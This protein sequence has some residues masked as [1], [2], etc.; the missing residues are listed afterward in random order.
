[1]NPIACHIQY[2]QNTTSASATTP[3]MTKIGPLT[4]RRHST[5]VQTAHKGV[6]HISAA[7]SKI[8]PFVLHPNKR[9]KAGPL[10]P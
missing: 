2:P 7:N 4:F 8:G 5:G 9:P 10:G 3:M 6:S 1:M